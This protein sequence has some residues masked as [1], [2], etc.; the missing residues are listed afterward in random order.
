MATRERFEEAIR[1]YVETTGDTEIG[2]LTD[3]LV[4]LGK[5]TDTAAQQAGQLL[6]ELSRLSDLSSKTRSFVELKAQLA[7]TSGALNKA[8]GDVATFKAQLEQSSDSPAK[9]ERALAKANSEVERLTKAQNRQQAELQRTSGALAKAGVDTTKLATANASLQTDLANV[10]SR[11]GAVAQ[12]MGNAGRAS[13]KAAS[14]IQ[15]VDKASKSGAASLAGLLG[16][17]S[18]V[19]VAVT[20]VLKGLELVSGAALFSGALRSASTLEDA[21]SSVQAVTNATADEMIALKVAAEDLGPRF[22]FSTLEAAQGLGELAR[23][24][25]SVKSAIAQLPATLALARAGGLGVAD[26]AAIVSTSLTQFGLA[27][28]EATRVADVLAKESNS[29]QD[30]VEKLGNALSYAAPLAKQLGLDIEQTTAIVGRLAEEGFKGE[31]AGT[32]LRS[33]FSEMIDAGSDFS[34]ALRD[35]NIDTSSFAS[36]I[37]GLAA[38]GDKGRDALLKLDAEARPAIL[39]LVSRG[40]GALRDL[41]AT[42]RK[43]GGEADATARKMGISFSGAVDQI[44][45][46]FDRARRSLVEP[47]LKPLREELASLSTEL[48]TFAKSPEFAEIQVALKDVFLE[49]AKGAREL[50]REIDFAALATS[51][52]DFL[53]DTDGSLTAFR[54][55]IGFV[56]DAVQA[57]GQ[58]I[59]VTFNLIQTIVLAVAGVVTEAISTMAEGIDLLT[60]IPRKML[61]LTGSISEGQYALADLA[62][63]MDAV[64]SEFFERMRTNA[65]ETAEAVAGFGEVFDGATTKVETGSKAAAAASTAAADAAKAQAEAANAATAALDSQAAAT[66]KV[67]DASRRGAAEAEAGAQRV[68]QAFADLGIQSQKDL[69]DAANSARRNFDLIRKAAAEGAASANDSRRAFVAYAAAARAAV[70]DSTDGSRERVESELLVLAAVT[71]STAA[72]KEMGAVGENANRRVS[73]SASGAATALGDVGAA[74]AGAAG[75][76]ESAGSASDEAAQ[77]MKEA[78]KEGQQFALSLYEV[79]QAGMEATMATNRFAGL[80]GWADRLNEVTARINAQGD[81]LHRQVA[82]L[83]KANAEFDELAQRRAELSGQYNL[84]GAGEIEK[85]LQAEQQLEQSRQRAAEKRRAADEQAARAAVEAA[86]GS[87]ATPEQIQVA[88]RQAGETAQIAT[89][90]LSQAQQTARTL[91]DAATTV[92]TAAADEIVIRIVS[93]APGNGRLNLSSAQIDEIAARVVRA[94]GNSKRSST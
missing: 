50:L 33:V 37:E 76:T 54:E 52:R 53:R 72:F 7:E 80:M 62:G 21:L 24:S 66:E 14:G 92:R 59:E 85:L 22:R 19:S 91:A 48:E 44:E 82:E 18:A 35:L 93:D 61:E 42:L 68:K 73:Q 31:R 23:A 28:G 36:T 12:E 78:S 70:A 60:A 27:A 88:R 3:Q 9:L 1:L 4:K 20:A 89:D 74:A 84:L 87:E 71:D 83:Q 43:A 26:A 29:T 77:K 10:A 57:L 41:E 6:E 5:G 17:L 15:S 38:N 34:K 51:I 90:L 64:S 56:V 81:A 49:G 65:G 45:G 86:G 16:K 32:A 30:S 11:A 39:A 69:N 67:A 13:G 40:G 63:G 75:N 94:I 79:S 8:K 58:T 55:N 25:G 47:L 2:Q 46:S